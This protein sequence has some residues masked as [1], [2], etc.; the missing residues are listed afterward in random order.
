MRYKARRYKY[1][2]YSVC[3]KVKTRYSCIL[4]LKTYDIIKGKVYVYKYIYVCVCVCVMMYMH[5]YT[6]IKYIFEIEI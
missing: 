5:A 2:R 1:L 6:F 4:L 3:K